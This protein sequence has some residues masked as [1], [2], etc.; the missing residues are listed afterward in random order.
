MAADLGLP[1]PTVRVQ[2]PRSGVRGVRQGET[3][4]VEQLG[5]LLT[6]VR[7]LY[8]QWYA[9]TY[10]LAF[11]GM[12]PGELYALRWSDIDEDRGVINVR[13]SVRRGHVTTTK[14]DAA[15]EVALTPG[16]RDV[17][18][19]KFEALAVEADRAEVDGRVRLADELRATVDGQNP[20]AVIFPAEGGGYRLPESIRKV[21]RLC[22][23][24]AGLSIRVGPQVLRRTLNTLLVEQ[25]TAGTVIRAQIGHTTEAM[26]DLYAGVH[27]T[28]KAQA[29][30][31]VENSLQPT[32][33]D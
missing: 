4:T 25:G 14:T 28:A 18:E 30:E 15:R 1:D 13:R 2:R 23:G 21:L 17:L 5:K 6:T 12:R 19:A 20:D 8:P 31:A 11:T 7:K 3:L 16:I 9:E 22:S 33:T 24:A 32:L 27:P 29:I 10:M 26:T